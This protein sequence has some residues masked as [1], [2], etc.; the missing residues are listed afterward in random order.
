MDKLT[1]KRQLLKDKV[2]SL[3]THPC[4]METPIKG[5]NVAMRTAPTFN[6]HCMYRP[7]AILVLQG[8]KEAV[9]GSE[10]LVYNENEIV[11]AS[12]DIPTVS[13]VVEA[14]EEKP[15]ITIVM[16]L[17]SKIIGQLM[18][19]GIV[20]SNEYS[21]RSMGV[22]KVSEEL[23]DAF[24]RLICL[25]DNPQRQKIMAPMILK[26]I[27][28]LLLTSSLG[29]I[30]ASVNTSGSQNNQIANA[31]S[32]LKENFKQPLKID[33]LAQKF[34]MAGSS[35]YRNFSKVTSLSPLQ[36]QKK[37]R[38]YE[39]HRMMLFEN[40]DVANAAYAVG[41]ESASQFSREYKRMFGVSPKINIG[42]IK[43]VQNVSLLVG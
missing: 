11:I 8:K 14:S 33:E 28:Y 30:L 31:V 19:E 34:N 3:F 4:I 23:L 12:V 32:W 2:Q 21:R 17:D 18:G 35:F 9:L 10:K 16:D 15:F 38:L 24:Y 13:S 22:E 29:D 26:E 5:I 20:A 36:Y 42:R 39:A 43:G 41:Y 25:V 40:V 27:Y 6:Q 1:E 7:M 37:L